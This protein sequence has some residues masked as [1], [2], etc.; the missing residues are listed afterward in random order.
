[1]QHFFRF[2]IL[3]YLVVLSCFALR[4]ETLTVMLYSPANPPYAVLEENGV[5]G[6]FVD[7]FNQVSEI[8]GDDFEFIHLPIARAL[9]EFDQGRIDIEPGV[10]PNWRQHLKVLGLYSVTY[11]ISEEVVVFSPGHF[12]EVLEPSDLFDE[13]VG[14][15][16]GFSYPR[17]DTAFSTDLI[18][19]VNNVSQTHLLEQLLHRRFEQIFVGLNTIKYFQKIKPQY[20]VLE[21]GN[22][23]D[24]QEVKMRV[25]P[26]NKTFMPRLNNALEQMLNAG[27]IDEIYSKYQ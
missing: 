18:I 14:I 7:I 11:A 16:R 15:V 12:K 23:V 26:S 24:R 21:I 6:I 3:L 22:V 13:A 20:R 5:S 25:H 4:A 19:R 9:H 27:K 1:M 17:F 10:N 8:T 2:V